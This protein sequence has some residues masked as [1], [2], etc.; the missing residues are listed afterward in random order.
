MSEIRIKITADGQAAINQIKAVG[1]AAKMAG[2]KVGEIGKTGSSSI[3]IATSSAD[4]FGSSLGAVAVKAAAVLGVLYAVKRAATAA[5]SPGYDFVKNMESSEL[6]ITAILQSMTLLDNKQMD[7]NTAM[8]ISRNVMKGLSKDAALTAARLEE[9]SSVYQAILAPGLAAGMDLSQIQELTTV[10]SN[11]VKAIF[12]N[13]PDTRR[14]MIQE[15][16]DLIS[17]GIQPS[18]SQLASALNISDADI[19]KAKGSA[20][21]LYKFLMDRLS[22][23]KEAAEHF[24][25]TLAGKEDLLKETA[26]RASSAFTKEFENELKGLLDYVTNLFGEIDRETGEFKFGDDFK[27][28]FGEIKDVIDDVKQSN[29]DLKGSFSW[30]SDDAV[31]VLKNVWGILKDV[32]SI[33]RGMS[34]LTLGTLAPG[35]QTLLGIVENV[36]FN[37]KQATDYMKDMVDYALK[38][39]GIRKEA[40]QTQSWADLQHAQ[41][42]NTQPAIEP[43][44]ITQRFPSNKN[45]IKE[46]QAAMKTATDAETSAAE[47]AKRDI[48]A[49]LDEIKALRD[50]DAMSETE[51]YKQKMQLELQL[52]QVEAQR[53][54]NIIDLTQD[55][56]FDKEESKTVKIADLQRQYDVA[57]KEVEVFG[58]SVADV[59]KITDNAANGAQGKTWN[60]ETDEVNIS[61][62]QENTISAIDALSAYFYN[63]TGK[64]MTVS[65]GFR[66]WGGH[67][68]GTKF[69]VVDDSVSE[70]LESNA[71]GIRDKI[72]EYAKSIGLS[73]L[74]EY[75]SPSANATAGHLDFEAS[76]F[77]PKQINS[78]IVSAMTTQIGTAYT[79][80]GAEVRKSIL[81]LFQKVEDVIK[82]LGEKRGDVS[83]GAKAEINKKYN[84]IIKKMSANSDLPGMK[85]AIDKVNDLRAISLNRIDLTQAQ[86]DI[87]I[88]NDMMVQE[89]RNTMNA[90]AAGTRTAAQGISDYAEVYY[91]STEK[92][93]KN[94]ESIASAA[95]DQQDYETY[96][97]ANEQLRAIPDKINSF[98]E[99]VVSSV[100][101]KL[102]RDIDMI[103][104]SDRTTLFKEEATKKAN[105][106][107]N[108]VKSQ[109]YQKAAQEARNSGNIALATS[110][111]EL[112]QYYQGLSH[113]K[114]M[115]EEVG[116]ASRQAF[117]D[118]LFTFLTD[119]IQQCENLAD[120]F[121]NLAKSVLS[122][123]N[124][125]YAKQLTKNIMVGLK[126]PQNAEGGLQVGPGTGTSDSFLSWLSNGEFVVKA[127][128]VQKFGSGFFHALNNGFLPKAAFPAFATGGMAG[129]GGVGDVINNNKT[130]L[131]IINV[132]DPNEVGRYIKSKAGQATFVNFIKGNK[133]VVK[134]LL[135]M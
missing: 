29:E 48:K 109:A 18:S 84:D 128:S 74:D 87:D 59:T 104:A 129:A 53:L 11:A 99:S 66:D 51:Y 24:P 63:L 1:D 13:N 117:E 130:G 56:L 30:L 108:G 32:D 10:G 50:Q 115:T 89:E 44:R 2:G 57:A 22:N 28:I 54:L 91:A 133:A 124:Q 97:S 39:S 33:F 67:V 4:G 111:E 17:G 116:I 27:Y 69:D 49:Q 88:A 31:P 82:E 101:A 121:R 105:A 75:D 43:S 107:A 134:R 55:T 114:T 26:T 71:D 45:A 122:S 127:A 102:Q 132:T 16:R 81:E 8:G 100:D 77:S 118:G 106:A 94:L 46:S 78:G 123:I 96:N 62:L 110:N 68:N 73:V 85:A 35:F 120:A 93:R 95:L 83:T 125:V 6:G 60:A 41:D 3:S 52:K 47:Q 36:T 135:E 98:V 92:A 34:V 42:T 12:P 14:Q 37:L 64:A 80:V 112:A 5:F 79:S 86:K 70:I 61:D 40:P 58:K 76:G 20:E 7:F 103:D 25:D 131:N 126:I 90:I 23:F 9:L 38:L 21:G 15:M 119:G 19:T 113:V 72:I 65:S